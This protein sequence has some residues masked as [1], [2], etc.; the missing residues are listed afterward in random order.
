MIT[1]TK[2]QLV[3]A[4]N[5]RKATKARRRPG[6][7]LVPERG[8]VVHVDVPIPFT[9]QRT[10]VVAKT[11]VAYGEGTSDAISVTIRVPVGLPA[12]L[13]T[14]YRA[15]ETKQYDSDV[16]VT[17]LHGDTAQHRQVAFALRRIPDM[18]PLA[19]AL[20]K[21]HEQL[22]HAI[23]SATLAGGSR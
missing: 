13:S 20:V 3:R 18:L 6:I 15:Q 5:I 9:S 22:A 8:E 4:K 19:A 10:D 1:A 14:D 21:L 17:Y 23:P 16:T 7:Q 11:I 12:T 2:K